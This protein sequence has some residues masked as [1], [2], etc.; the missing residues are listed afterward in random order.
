MLSQVGVFVYQIGLGATRSL[1]CTIPLSPQWPANAP[2]D[3][4]PN[5]NLATTT[6]GYSTIVNYGLLYQCGFASQ[7]SPTEI[8][9]TGI[10]YFWV[11]SVGRRSDG[12]PTSDPEVEISATIQVNFDSVTHG[13][14]LASINNVQYV[15]PIDDTV[16]ST[17]LVLFYTSNFD[18]LASS[19]A[20]TSGT[21]TMYVEHQLTSN[22]QTFFMQL[23]RAWF[24]NDTNGANPSLYDFSP[25]S[26]AF[27]NVD[28]VSIP[29][30]FRFVVV[31]PY[32]LD[33]EPCY[34]H[35]TSQLGAT[36]TKQTAGDTLAIGVNVESSAGV[37]FCK[38]NYSC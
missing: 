21:D 18:S 6:T 15:N 13:V 17:S 4:F 8:V 22:S 9:M 10:L 35:L 36:G 14:T 24:T 34:L 20:F 38:F 7:T 16:F 5:R 1:P 29:G 19:P 31:A 11:F 32:V 2:S 23:I 3:S 33:C 25:D 37:S 27:I 30:R 26:S 12:Q 28:I